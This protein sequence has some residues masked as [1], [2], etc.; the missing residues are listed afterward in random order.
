MAVLLRVV[1]DHESTY[2]DV[3]ALIKRR[4]TI[5]LFR[6]RRD[7]I[8]AHEREGHHQ[9][10]PTIGRVGEAFRITHHGGVEDYLAIYS[11]LVA[12]AG[13]TKFVSTFKLQSNFSFIHSCLF[14]C[15]VVLLSGE[16]HYKL[17]M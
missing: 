10:L 1:A 15:L 13:A 6:S 16:E 14:C 12:E 9:Y 17:R 11:L 8:I 5:C 7:A 3:V 2:M 4:K